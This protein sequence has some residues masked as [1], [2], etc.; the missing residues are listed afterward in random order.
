MTLLNKFIIPISISLFL[1]ACGGGSS[2]LNVSPIAVDDNFTA[3]INATTEL[4]IISN[5]S[6]SDGSLDNSSIT[7]INDASQGSISI[8]SVTGLI[9]YTANI[10][11]LGTDSFTYTLNDDDGSVSNVAT[12]T[13]TL[14]TD[15]DL[16][17]IGDAIDTDDDNDGIT[18]IEEQNNNTDSLN[19]DSDSD[20]INDGTEGIVD[21]DDDGIIDALESAIIDVD[22]DGV[23]DQQDAE[24]VNPNNDS[25][26]DSFSNADE[27]LNETDPLN[28]SSFPKPF[29]FKVKSE[30][31]LCFTGGCGSVYTIK[32]RSD[33]EYSYSVDCNSDGIMEASN[34]TSEY[35]CNYFGHFESHTISIHGQ[36]PIPNFQNDNTLLSIE[37]WGTY[38]YKSMNNA[39][40]NTTNLEINAKDKPNLKNV[41]DMSYMFFGS[42]INQ[43]IS[44]W[45]V[46]SVTNMSSMF[47]FARKFNQDI[48]S[49]DVSSVTDMSF[50]FSGVERIPPVCACVNFALN[51]NQDLSLWNVS[52][53]KDMTSMFD[54]TDLSSENY[55]RLLIAWKRLQLQKNV[56]FGARSTRYS[57]AAEESRQSIIDLYNWN[58]RDAGITP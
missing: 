42:S 21:T 33:Y 32:T 11:S 52:N 24:N 12:V 49:W 16:D 39:F 26:N 14:D 28:S 47:H 46:S 1:S 38:P 31:G 53:V 19:N 40:V 22:N 30:E 44:N 9:S 2:T 4:N 56:T 57:Q 3:I 8:N 34:L 6:D 35:E 15:N 45:D 37:Q 25:D 10:N 7:V 48:S 29:I 17:N 43:D 27:I 18:D 36:Y 51:F 41:S 54:V 55:N 13:I 20:G 58:I 50:M 5:D 23:F